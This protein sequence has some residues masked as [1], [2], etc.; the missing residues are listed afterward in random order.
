MKLAFSTLGVPGMA[1]EQVLRLAADS[2]FQGV[3][4]RAS[5]GE[6]V[7]T[8]LDTAARSAVAGRFAGAGLVP[9]TIASYTRVAA[10]GDDASLV[11]EIREHVRLAADIGAAFV[12]VFPGGGDLPAA[13]ADDN[14]VRRLAE[15]APFA[16][17]LG[18]R[19]LLETHDS[20]PRAADAARVLARL[21]YEGAGVIWDVMHTWRAGEAPQD[22]FTAAAP[23]LGYVQVKDIAG[24]DDTTPLPLGAG[25]LPLGDC[26]AA[27]GSGGF[28]GWVC[29]EYEAAWYPEAAA[30]PEL[31][32]DG[33]RYLRSLMP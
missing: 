22:S 21:G 20:H 2:G 3:E 23:Y 24:R 4:L 1:L 14:A 26:V 11:A 7:T 25:V 16:A 31:L 18:V 28:E 12:R 15:V 29:W 27:L 32:P 9:L 8:G 13:K 5:E 19:V 17:D 30:F 33:A 6:P 10:E